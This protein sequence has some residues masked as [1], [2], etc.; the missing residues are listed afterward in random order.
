MPNIIFI[1]CSVPTLLLLY[2]WCLPNDFNGAGGA[3]FM[4][5]LAI[6]CLV[7]VLS[8]I[9]TIFGLVACFHERENKRSIRKAAIATV[10][11]A[12]PGLYLLLE[13]A[14]NQHR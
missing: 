9:M 2:L 12:G 14:S 1:F 13:A 6:L 5:F 3:F 7:I 4:Q 11:A 8:P 10:L